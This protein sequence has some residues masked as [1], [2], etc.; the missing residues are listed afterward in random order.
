V[1]AALLGSSLI[2]GGVPIAI[3]VLGV[4]ALVTIVSRRPGRRWVLVF[5]GAA[6]VGAAVG[7]ALAWYLGDVRNAFDVTLAF[8]TRAWFAVGIAGIAIAVASLWRASRWRV[9]VALGS[10][11]VF[12]LVAGVGIN[13]TIGE[14][15]TVA[16]ALG[17]NKTHPLHIAPH[18]S[19]SITADPSEA[20]WKTWHA[21]PDMPRQGTVGTVVLPASASRFV[22][23]DGIVYLPPAALVAHAPRLPVLVF[24]GG[25]PGSPQT[26]LTAGQLPEILNAFANSHHGLAPVVVVPDQLG[27][28]ESNPMC[29]DSPLGHVA[30]YLT[31]DVPGWIKSHLT[32][33]TDR[34][35]WAIGG[36]SEGGTCSIQLGTKYRSLFGDILDI[37]GQAAPLNGTVA[38]TIAVGFGGSK[39]AYQAGTARG[40]LAAGAPFSST[41]GIFVV[42][43]DDAKYGPQTAV[44]ERDARD[45]SMRVSSYL[46]PGTAHDWYT[47]QYGL[48][49]GLP[50]LA[51]S[52][53]LES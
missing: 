49:V 28:S 42:G 23:R 19:P 22:A 38:H 7:F 47:E 26:V 29:L 15:P 41:L 39:S 25:Q 31:V 4:V 50:I 37:S 34:D 14:F 43:Q 9:P 5:G 13:A 18:A 11:V 40:L 12:A 30:T 20:L 45:A 44:V 36:F 16:D 10:I 46:S 51:R 1:F 35:D 48:T 27:S 33:R 3:D 52:W 17:V 2:D 21:P 6:A 53:G 24:L 32:V 8:S